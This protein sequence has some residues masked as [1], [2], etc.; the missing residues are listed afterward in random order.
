MLIIIANDHAHVAG[1]ASEVA[2]REAILLKE[3]GHKVLFLAC[4]LPVD[5]RLRRANIE[6]IA[7]GQAELKEKN[8]ASGI[9]EGIWNFNLSRVVADLAARYKRDKVV[10]H[11][12]SFSK[13]L[14]SSLFVYAHRAGWRILLTL[15][16]YFVACPNG[17]FYDYQNERI[18][19]LSGLGVRCV[20]V[21]CDKRR[22]AHKV[23]RVLRNSALMFSG[24]LRGVDG[25]VCLSESSQNILSKHLA[26]KRIFHLKNPSGFSK[27]KINSVAEKNTFSYVGQLSHEKGPDII[28]NVA[29]QMGLGL[30]LAGEGALRNILVGTGGTIKVLGW[31]KSEEV[32]K[33]LDRSR[34]LLFPSRW[35]E[36]QPLAPLEAMAKGVPIIVSGCS[37]AREYVDKSG[38]GMI[39]NDVESLEEWK[40]C[41]R[42]MLLP[43]VAE[44]MGRAAYEWFW[45]AWPDN[46]AHVEA[47]VEIYGEL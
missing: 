14:T 13:A 33:L 23:F 10:L 47:L 41:I 20:L 26:G 43:E 12:H 24:A 4:V 29:N 31:Q 5:D 1:G 7:T 27:K 11:V 3:G 25:F 6:V 42:K 18:C 45:S 22:Y 35:Y 32:G 46:K 8:G 30:E 34:C 21:N 36:V 15:H 40:A 38:G 16:D 44:A 19:H 39:V 17:G 28:A 9:A 37:A 2:I